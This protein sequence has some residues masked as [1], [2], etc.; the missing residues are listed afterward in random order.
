[1]QEQKCG[2][3]VLEGSTEKEREEMS[4]DV[5]CIISLAVSSTFGVHFSSTSI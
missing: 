2:M 5:P 4:V 3:S 1:M